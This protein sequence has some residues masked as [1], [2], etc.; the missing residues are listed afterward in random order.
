MNEVSRANRNRLHTLS[1]TE[2]YTAHLTPY[3]QRATEELNTK[4]Q[5]T[6]QENAS[7]VAKIND[8]RAEIERLLNS[9]DAAVKE[10]EDSVQ[11]MQVD[12][13]NNG[14]GDLRSDVWQME[15]EVAAT[16]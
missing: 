7:V 14:L 13:G 11:A 10:A 4:L 16:R 1:A 15:Q 12:G 8:Q 3:F 6:Q 2:L 9:L 5:Q